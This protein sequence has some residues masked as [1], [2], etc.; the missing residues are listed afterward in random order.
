MEELNIQRDLLY[1]SPIAE[2]LAGEKLEEKLY[3]L[4]KKFINLKLVKRGVKEVG[5]SIRKGH[6]GLVILAADISPPDVLSHLPVQCENKKIPYIFVRSRLM[7]GNSADTK[8]PTS[9]VMLVE[10]GK[11]AKEAG[12]FKKIH[13][14][15]FQS[16]YEN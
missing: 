3:K 6:K 9:V 15:I 1:V 4:T 7:L 8:R 13:K 14:K 10:P 5:K 12:K 16:Q 11:D 2:P